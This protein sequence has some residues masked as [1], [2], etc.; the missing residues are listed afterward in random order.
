MTLE[1]IAS[2]V[3]GTVT[4]RGT[5][6]VFGV[7][8]PDDAGAE[9]L[10]VAWDRAV[11]A[12]LPLDVPVLVRPGEAG[13]RD[14][15]E[16]DDPR[17][18]LPVLLRAFTPP[19]DF[20]PGI[21]PSAVVH[22]AAAVDPD[23]TVGPLCVVCAGARI[24]RGAVLEAQ[25]FCGEG[26]MVGEDARI[27]PQVVLGEAT[28]VG[29][30]VVIH[31]G[32]VVGADGFGFLPGPAGP[33]KIPQVGRVVIEDDVEIGALNTIDRATVG[34]TRIGHGTKTDDHVHVGHN[35]R[36]GAHCLLVAFT[37]LAGSTS[38]GDGVTMA[39]RSGTRPHVS[40]GRGATIAGMAGVTTDVPEKAVVSGFPA[41]EHR[42][43]LRQQA[44]VRRLPELVARL[45]A[46][47][48]KPGGR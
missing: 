47:E 3:G 35:S 19:R 5:R 31:A 23:A 20:V 33:I 42:A 17:G 30:R 22:P 24:G 28:R 10:C 12:R 36:I 8:A 34:E 2:L 48:E 7:A 27:A 4:G 14:G 26:V 44:L 16:V 13:G 1:E 39:A 29:A 18:A 9:T 40:I 21:H 11:A 41:Q 37:G 25:V 32:T 43:E 46:L 6:D 15:V 45:K 38:L